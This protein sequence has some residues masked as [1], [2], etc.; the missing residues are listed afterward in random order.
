MISQ[1]N[2]A[3]ESK[4]QEKK[5]HQFHSSIKNSPAI[6]FPYSSLI[7]DLLP[8]PDDVNYIH[9]KCTSKHARNC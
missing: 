4:I 1:P 5:F 6:N 2:L 7:N 3:F 9:T 8:L